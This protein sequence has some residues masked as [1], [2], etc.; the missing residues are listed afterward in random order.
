MDK[1]EL[2]SGH[3]HDRSCAIGGTDEQEETKSSPEYPR[4][5][6]TVEKSSTCHCSNPAPTNSNSESSTGCSR[7]NPFV[8]ELLGPDIDCV[9]CSRLLLDPVTV[10]CGHSFCKQCLQ[11]ALDFANVCPSCR[12][13]MHFD[14]L[15][16]LPVSTV[17]RNII[18]TALPQEYSMRRREVE[19]EVEM[20]VTNLFC[21]M[22][23]FVL[24]VVV[25]PGQESSYCIFEP[26]YRLMLR[27]VMQGSRRFGLVSLRRCAESNMEICDVGCVLEVTSCRRLP[28]GRSL[29][30]TIGRERFRIVE[31]EE[32]DGYFIAR[33]QRVQDEEPEPSEAI[34]ATQRARRLVLE[35][36]HNGGRGTGPSAVRALLEVG[37]V[38]DE[39]VSASKFGM[40]LATRAIVDH[41]E[42]QSLLEET[43]PVQR[44]VSI[45][46]MLEQE[47]RVSSHPRS[48][49][50]DCALQ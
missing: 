13:V 41:D 20:S 27:R 31:R 10:P 21:R 26:R 14:D 4:G 33:T 16:T 6:L 3:H 47:N 32:L 39:S 44:L 40:W 15:V 12:S 50:G 25:F 18:E 28:D 37:T 7:D 5:A 9:I 8:R 45:A 24:N 1:L 36:L 42:R 38:P 49:Q 22:P 34:S 17:L 23:L 46:R 2:D 48:G 30:D 35:L 19:A 11:R 29:I 43:N